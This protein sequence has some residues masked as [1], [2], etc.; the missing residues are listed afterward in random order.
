MLWYWPGISEKD[1]DVV[2]G[3]R[4]TGKEGCVLLGYVMLRTRKPADA[5]SQDTR[6]EIPPTFDK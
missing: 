3:S 2:A 5:S 4:N 6:S 1:Q